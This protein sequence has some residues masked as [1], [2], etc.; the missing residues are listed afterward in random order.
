MADKLAENLPGIDQ[1]LTK[2]GGSSLAEAVDGYQ[3]YAIYFSAHWCP[4]CRNF[5]PMLAEFY[6]KVNEGGAKNI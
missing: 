2:D 1:V 4:P 3:Y 5:T 6:N